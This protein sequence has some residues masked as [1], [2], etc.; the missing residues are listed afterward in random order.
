[1][2]VPKEVLPIVLVVTAPENAESCLC[3][4]HSI[5]CRGGE[6]GRG[7]HLAE[8]KCEAVFIE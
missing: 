8:C 5:K 1:M 3:S 4:N 7:D 6:G 2:N